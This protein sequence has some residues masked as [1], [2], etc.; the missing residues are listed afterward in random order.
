MGNKKKIRPKVRDSIL[1]SLR[2]GV[3]PRHGLQHIQVGRAG[4]VK[5]LFGDIERIADGGSAFRFVIGEYGSGKTFFLNLIRSIALEKKLVTVHADMT[6]DRRLQASNGQ[7]RTLYAELMRNVATRNKPDGGAMTSIVERFVTAALQEAVK[8]SM[9]PDEVIAGR[10]ENLSEMVGGYD[11]AQV[12]AAY[13]RGHD[14]GNEQLKVDAVR[15]LRAEFTTKT[16]ARSALGIRTFINDSSFFDHLKLSAR[17]VRLAGYSGLLVCLD[18]MVNLYKIQNSKS[19]NGN[20]EQILRMLNDSLQGVSVGLGFLMGGTPEFMLDTR[21]GLY[22]YEALQSRLSENTFTRDGLL[23]FSGPVLRLANLSPEDLFVLLGKLRHV[24]AGG[25]PARYI[26]PDEA[27]T[28]FME[29]CQKRIGEA[30]FRTP[31]TTIRAFL[32]LLSIL[33]QN[34][35]TTWQALVGEVNVLPDDVTGSGISEEG[36]DV[37]GEGE[38]GLTT[39]K[40]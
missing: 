19:R 18:E 5:A 29:H 32:D 40:L 33:D 9:R 27:L 22:S 31:R 35:G 10:L 12:I 13:W 11:F 39:F 25:D 24:H 3:V 2:A 34:P 28:A 7:A 26:V 36:E 6:P 37:K 30:Y 21:R 1:Q 38:D 15:W 14:Q 8:K 16:D 20:Y 23:D 17:F 4:E